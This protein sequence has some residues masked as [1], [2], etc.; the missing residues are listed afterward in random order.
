MQEDRDS[1]EREHPALATLEQCA[2]TGPSDGKVASHLATCQ[3]CRHYIEK[4][5]EQAEVFRAENGNDKEFFI[6]GVLLRAAEEGRKPVAFASRRTL[7]RMGL[8]TAS[9]AAAASLFLF[10]HR[11]PPA[12]EATPVAERE[13]MRFKG[14]PVVAL[15][16]ERNGT[17]ARFAGDVR[18]RPDD[19]VRVEISS[20][21]TGPLAAGILGDD[22]T[23]IPLLAAVML[24]PGTHFSERVVRFDEH[25]TAGW[26]LVGS[27]DAVETARVSRA[28]TM[29]RA[30]RVQ[31][32]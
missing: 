25:P 23:W 12:S 9:L 29:V 19:R 13:S 21:E 7:Q 32:E 3:T 15:V 22:G 4:L 8:A 18:V 1:R 26:I 11:Q 14:G 27:P 20:D 24:P 30:L 2:A 6:A 31:P 28:F 10:V 16:R 5:R 17:Q